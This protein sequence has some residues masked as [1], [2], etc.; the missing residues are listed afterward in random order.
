MKVMNSCCLRGQGDHS[1]PASLSFATC[2]RDRCGAE[3]WGC[4]IKKR[5][6]GFLTDQEMNILNRK[7]AKLRISMYY[8]QFGKRLIV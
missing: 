8:L 1:Q 6:T 7:K 4:N 3:L 5:H 2:V